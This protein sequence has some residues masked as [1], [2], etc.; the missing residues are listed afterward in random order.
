MIDPLEMR[1]NDAPKLCLTTTFY[2]F[3][4]PI[5]LLLFDSSSKKNEKK[6]QDFRFSQCLFHTAYINRKVKVLSYCTCHVYVIVMIL[7][8]NFYSKLHD[9][10]R[11]IENIKTFV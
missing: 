4:G 7:Q 5:G 8:R 6:C 2:L 3:I 1:R 9:F 10:G 11:R